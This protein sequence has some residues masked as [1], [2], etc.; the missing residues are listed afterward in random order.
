MFISLSHLLFK[1]TG[2]FGDKLENNRLPQEWREVICRVHPKAAAYTEF[3]A[4][5]NNTLYVRVHDSIWVVELEVYKE[6]I[7]NILNQKRKKPIQAIRF[8]LA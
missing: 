2:G 3:Q 8:T 6:N 1:K 5:H 4:F 7:K